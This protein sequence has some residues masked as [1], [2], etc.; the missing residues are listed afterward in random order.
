VKNSI[1]ETG[2]INLNRRRICL[3]L[4]FFQ[5]S[6]CW[7]SLQD[8][9]SFGNRSWGNAG[10]RWKRVHSVSDVRVNGE[11]HLFTSF[12]KIKNSARNFCVSKWS[13]QTSWNVAA[14][15]KV[16]DRFSPPKKTKHDRP[17]HTMLRQLLPPSASRRRSRLSSALFLFD[18][19][20]KFHSI[21]EAHLTVLTACLICRTD[22]KSMDA[23]L[24][25]DVIKSVFGET[26][27]AYCYHSILVSHLMNNK[28]GVIE[29]AL[30]RLIYIASSWIFWRGLSLC[31]VFQYY[32]VFYSYELFHHP[33]VFET[34]WPIWSP[35]FLG[36]TS[37]Y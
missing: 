9:L 37:H 15:A 13:A 8:S 5:S 27:L 14:R 21:R 28:N 35:S 33:K 6:T 7:N 16:A 30:K 1:L 4:Q 31:I 20:Q 25:Q 36:T 12:P 2:S 10:R 11:K 26:L 3:V 32:F 24:L 22:R 19:R 29:I 18:Y 34:S 17:H 23:C